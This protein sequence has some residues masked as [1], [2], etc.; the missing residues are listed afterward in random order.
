MGSENSVNLM[1]PQRMSD[2]GL[3]LDE[4]GPLRCDERAEALRIR[5][6][7]GRKPS[8]LRAGAGGQPSAHSC[9]S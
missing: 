8:T 4:L 1:P 5:G 7:P 2:I 3:G 6:Y 9:E